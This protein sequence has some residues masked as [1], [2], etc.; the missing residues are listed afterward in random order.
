MRSGWWATF[1]R[2]RLIINEKVYL[3]R[4]ELYQ[5]RFHECMQTFCW[6][7][8]FPRSSY[9]LFIKVDKMSLECGWLK[10]LYSQLFIFQVLTR[11]TVLAEVWVRRGRRTAAVISSLRLLRSCLYTSDYCQSVRPSADHA[12]AAALSAPGL[13]CA[14]L[15]RC[16]H[17]DGQCLYGYVQQWQWVCVAKW[18]CICVVQVHTINFRFALQLEV[19]YCIDPICPCVFWGIQR[20][21]RRG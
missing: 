20:M 11:S 13:R 14:A 10:H 15:Q 8:R 5:H 7:E 3:P 6:C 21:F 19:Y 16:P 18:L 4:I 12:S 1:L 2:Q 9:R 17:P